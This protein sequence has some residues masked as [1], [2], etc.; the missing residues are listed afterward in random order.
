MNKKLWSKKP[1]NI[2]SEIESLLS[3]E[4]ILL[5]QKLFLLDIKASFAHTNELLAI[6]ILTKSEANKI[7]KQLRILEKKYINN[8]FK[9]NSDYEDS[10]SAIELFLTDELGAIGAKIHTGRS[11]NDQVLVALRLYAREALEQLRDINIDIS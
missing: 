5:D 1:K 8:T 3:G 7:K 10:H 2:T 6:N 4:D 9:L 11:R